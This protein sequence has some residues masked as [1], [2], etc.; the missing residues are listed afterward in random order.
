MFGKKKQ[1][2]LFNSIDDS[3]TLSYDFRLRSTMLG[4]E[5][6]RALEYPLYYK[7]EEN[8]MIP[9]IDDHLSK[10]FSGEIDDANGDMLDSI[11]F[12]AAREA[13]PELNR[14]RYNHMDTLRR[15]IVRETVDCKDIERI[16][17][18]REIECE[19]LQIER[20]ELSKYK[21]V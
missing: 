4:F 18:E 5:S 9:R 8:E 21:E 1:Q 6:F 12:G 17:Q 7:L 16:K 14:Q 10:M 3:R 11:I 2:P 19:Q 13:L 15:L 20:N